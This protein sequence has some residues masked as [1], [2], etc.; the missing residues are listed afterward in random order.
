MEEGLN[1]LIAEDEKTICSMYLDMFPKEYS[2]S[3]VH[4]GKEALALLTECR[5]HY[6]I[7]IVDYYL[8]CFSGEEAVCLAS[9][10]GCEVPI[11]YVTGDN[12]MIGENVLAKPFGYDNLMDKVRTHAIRR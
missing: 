4:T 8:P 5:D 2:L 7:A 12:T 11:L 10:L 3:I 9:A 1:I 6:D